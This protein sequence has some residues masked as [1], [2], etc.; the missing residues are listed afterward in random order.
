VYGVGDDDDDVYDEG[1][2]AYKQTIKVQ[3]QQDRKELG[4]ARAGPA[5]SCCAGSQKLLLLLLLSP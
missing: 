4:F 2:I 3:R 5:P 1:E